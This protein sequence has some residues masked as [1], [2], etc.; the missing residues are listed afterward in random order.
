MAVLLIHL[1]GALQAYGTYTATEVRPTESHP[2][3]SAVVGLLAACQGRPRAADCSDLAALPMGIAVLREGKRMSD[4][5]TV[6][7]RYIPEAGG[8]K[9]TSKHGDYTRLSR[10]HYL[11]DAAFVVGI[12]TD[13]PAPLVKDLKKPHFAPYL[14]RRSCTPSRPLYRDVHE[15]TL[16]QALV[17]LNPVRM[18]LPTRAEVE[19]YIPTHAV[20]LADVPLGNRRFDH[21]TLHIYLPESRPVL[22][23]IRLGPGSRN[24]RA[25]LY[26]MHRTTM[27][28]TDS[29][30]W[31]VGDGVL[32]IQSDGRVDPSLAREDDWGAVEYVEAVPSYMSDDIARLSLWAKVVRR[33]NGHERPIKD[34]EGKVAWLRRQGQRHGFDVIAVQPIHSRWVEGKNGVYHYGVQFEGVV[35]VIDEDAFDKALTRGIGRGRSMGFGMMRTEPLNV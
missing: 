16:N 13:N 32:Y 24:D 4:Y 34:T 5:H 18:L 29:S 21:R 12:E 30:L 22:T 25:S 31:H 1:E 28:L 10:R 33:N 9:R 2:T 3:K 35:R 11:A 8:G 20:I 26:E 15:G 27:R 23:A 19:G 7:S 6:T 17:C 14:G